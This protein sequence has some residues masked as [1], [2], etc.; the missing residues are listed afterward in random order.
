[1]LSS[2]SA[3]IA[4][5]FGAIYERNAINAAL[6]ILN[7]NLV[8]TDIRDG[9]RIRVD[10]ATGEITRLASGQ[11]TQGQPFPGAQMTIYQRGGLLIGS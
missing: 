8:T 1:M 10:L 2:R 11:K 9:E 7:A 3:A 6:P 4:Q 5:S